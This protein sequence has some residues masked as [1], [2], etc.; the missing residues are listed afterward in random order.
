MLSNK[1]ALISTKTVTFLLLS[2]T[3]LFIS[4]VKDSSDDNS[5]TD[6]TSSNDSSSKSVSS[7]GVSTKSRPN[8]HITGLAND[9]GPVRFKQ[10]N[11]GCNIP[12]CTFRH[13]INQET[14]HTFTTESFNSTAKATN[15]MGDGTYYLHVQAQDSDGNISAVKSVFVVMDHTAPTIL[16]LENDPTATRSKT[17]SWSCNETCTYR[18]AINTSSSHCFSTGEPFSNTVTATQDKGDGIYYLHVEAQDLAG[19]ISSLRV[20]AMLDNT[21]PIILG[22]ADDPTTAYSKTWKWNCDDTNC[23]YRYRVNKEST[24]TFSTELFSTVVE[25]TQ[26]VG[27]GTY[28]LHVEVSDPSGN[29]S[30]TRVSAVLELLPLRQYKGKKLFSGLYLDGHTMPTLVD[31][32]RDNIQDLV[33]GNR[34]GTLKY[35]QGTAT[36]FEEKVGSE[37]NPFHGIDVGD[38]SAPTFADLDKDGDLELVIGEKNGT[39]KYYDLVGEDTNSDNI[40]DIWIWTEQTGSANPF[41]GI[42]MWSSTYPHP[43]FADL[44]TDTDLELVIGETDGTLK[45][46]DL[47]GSDTNNDN[48]DDTWVWTK[49]TGSNNPFNDL[50]VND[51]TYLIHHASRTVSPIFANIDKDTDLELIIGN[52]LGRLKYYDLVG[53]TWAEQTGANN[54]FN[55]I[56]VGNAAAPTF[57]DLDND[58]KLELIIGEKDGILNYYDL[59]EGA[60]TNKTTSSN[61]FYALD[62]GN[63]HYDYAAPTFA[64]LDTDP[65]LEL[66]MGKYDGTL[67]YYDLVGGKWTEQTGSNNPFNSVGW[68]STNGSYS[69][70]VFVNL[71]TDPDLEL[72]LGTDFNNLI[73]YYNWSGTTWTQQTG[74]NNPFGGLV[75]EEGEGGYAP[76]F[77]DLDGDSIVEFVLGSSYGNLLYF[78]KSGGTWTKQAHGNNPFDYIIASYAVPVFANLDTDD[79][80]ELVIGEYDGT[81][82]Y[83]DLVGKT[84]VEQTG[85]SNPF[86]T[87]DAGNAATPTFANLDD[88]APLEF[89]LGVRDGTLPFYGD[90]YQGEWVFFTSCSIWST[91]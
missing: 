86:N 37:N 30:S 85:A 81:L 50:N 28:Y 42:R 83:Y 74:L 76:T 14:T 19:N 32:N 6:D 54:P 23:S 34:D 75:F 43:T 36:G 15:S 2:T 9:L 53:E 60:W 69:K 21:A 26:D 89:V 67:G 39:L 57:A 16:G 45:Y 73:S 90:F 64:D 80:L 59:V 48:I 40:D 88:D 82:N 3:F 10:W 27:D 58:D 46:Y 7:K 17:W 49:Q 87:I 68:G 25:A 44:D 78:E 22:L 66:V 79:D 72:V 11:Y 24:Y 18:Y 31:V 12:P 5:S 84:W 63:T 61:P 56:D 8:F 13:L 20:S 52:N 1:Q 62:A 4:C 65:D 35:Y 33:I 47:V 55:D 77:A 70:P 51:L 38:H 71:D 29:I 41:D 91:C